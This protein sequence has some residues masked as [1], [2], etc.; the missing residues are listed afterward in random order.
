MAS[1]VEYKAAINKPHVMDH[2][3][4]Q[5][6]QAPPSITVLYF[7][8]LFSLAFPALKIQA[9][10]DMRFGQL[11]LMA[12]F[13]CIFLRD[14]YYR[15]TEW[16]VL[17]LMVWVGLLFWSMSSLSVYP[18][19]KEHVF[20]V[21]HAALYPA[22]MY[23]GVRMVR[24]IEPKYQILVIEQV[25]GLSCLVAVALHFYPVAG[26][27]HERPAHLSV[28]LKGSFWEQDEF[29]FF[30]G[31]FLLMSLTIRLEHEIWP[32]RKTLLGILYVAALGCALWS[33]NK[34]VWIALN[35]VL[36]SLAMNAR[37]IAY[38]RSQLRP[39][40]LRNQASGR[41]VAWYCIIGGAVLIT[42][43]TA[44]NLCLPGDQR[45]VSEAM[46]RHK[47]E[48][49]RGAA[50]MASIETI[51]QE[52]WTGMGFGSVAGYFVPR[53]Y[54]I[55][56]VSQEMGQLF[57][58]FLDLWM[59]VGVLGPL[60]LVVMLWASFSRHSFPAV[61]V[62]PYLLVWMM[63]NPVA[64][65]EYFYFFVGVSFGYARLTKAQ[66]RTATGRNNGEGCGTL[67]H[68]EL[69]NKLS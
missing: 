64:Q 25:L 49:E 15:R 62:A 4:A 9:G 2:G 61:V 5:G 66:R 55:I 20:V 40:P 3:T 10:L 1:A 8:V 24:L 35:L 43:L 48:A 13:A 67:G 22:S 52:P 6:V 38:V 34:S 46:L 39:M 58:S 65:L 30:V 68:C 44:F 27:I 7:F 59:S 19:I 45:L 14:L 53:H 12:V 11:V 41:K 63:L 54:G 69:P 51:S 29:A 17:L 32:K 31:V 28:H 47:W 36:L 56:G 50:L 42:C 16:D 21:K 37:A 18:K 26:L 23:L 60:F 57:N 33:M